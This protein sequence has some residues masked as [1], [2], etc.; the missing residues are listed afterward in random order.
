MGKL[1][2]LESINKFRQDARNTLNTQYNDFVNKTFAQSKF[3]LDQA[4]KRLEEYKKTQKFDSNLTQQVNDGYVYNAAGQRMTDASG[5]PIRGTQSKPIEQSIDNKDGT[6]SILYKDGTFEKIKAGMD[7]SRIPDKS[8]TEIM[9]PST[10][11]VYNASGAIVTDPQTGL[12]VK[13]VPEAG[14]SQIVKDDDGNMYV[15]DPKSKTLE[16]YT[17]N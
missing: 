9:G 7:V 8:I 16:Q 17:G 15:F 6:Y 12:P 10:G 13:Y 1:D 14:N 3:V 11:Y 5:Q 4:E 2:S